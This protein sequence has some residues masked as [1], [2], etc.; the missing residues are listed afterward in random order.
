MGNIVLQATVMPESSCQLGG[1]PF[2]RVP[3]RPYNTLLFVSLLGQEQ[4]YVVY[5]SAA[6]EPQEET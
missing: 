3:A 4:S 2:D 1:T 5:I 6:I